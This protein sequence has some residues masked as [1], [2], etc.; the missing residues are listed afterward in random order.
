MKITSV[1]IWGDSVLKGI[2]F[3]ESRGRYAILRDNAPRLVESALGLPVVNHSRMGCTAPEGLSELMEDTS[4]LHGSLVLIE[5]GGNDCDMDWAA[6]AAEPEG[7]HR[8][9]TLPEKFEESLRAMAE[10]V[11]S[12][13]GVPVLCTLPPLNAERYLQWVSR[14][15]SQENILKYLGGAAARIYRWQEFYS[16]M[17]LRL[18]SELRCL[19]LPVREYFLQQMV[20]QD[21]HSL[22]GIHLNELGHKMLAEAA[23]GA[24]QKHLPGLR[25]EM[26][27]G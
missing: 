2:F 13:G 8:P 9:K 20:S 6:V 1:Q 25:Q 23:L 7:E 16:S 3:D 10:L 19:C 12:R 11:R 5:Y 15:L 17:A 22:D 14:G 4:A 21:V 26:A 27:A 24:I 18:S